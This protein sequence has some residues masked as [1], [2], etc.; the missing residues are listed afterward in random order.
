MGHRSRRGIV[1]KSEKAQLIENC[2][3]EIRVVLD[4]KCDNSIVSTRKISPDQKSKVK[5]I[6]YEYNFKPK[7]ICN[8]LGVEKQTFY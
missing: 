8:I 6:I 4:L 7:L 1:S 5:Q 3:G 2:V